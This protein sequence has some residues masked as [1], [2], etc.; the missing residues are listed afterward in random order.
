MRHTPRAGNSCFLSFISIIPFAKL[1]EID[2]VFSYAVREDPFGRS[3][4][5]CRFALVATGLLQ[6]GNDDVSL[7]IGDRTLEK[8]VVGP[9]FPCLHILT[10]TLQWRDQGDSGQPMAVPPLSPEL[11]RTKAALFRHLGAK[12]APHFFS[13]PLPNK[14]L[15]GPDSFLH[16]FNV[17][18]PTALG[19]V[20]P[21]RTMMHSS[22]G[23]LNSVE[24]VI[25]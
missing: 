18:Q 11:I 16:R 1:S 10:L 20:S 8:I 7:K 15:D 17:F 23:T 25:G 22:N 12:S 5:H 4:P 19:P 9:Q 24:E 3:Q 6:G 21:L 14:S 2:P 13:T